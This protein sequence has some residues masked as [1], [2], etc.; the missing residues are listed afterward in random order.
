MDAFSVIVLILSAV[1]LV[2]LIWLLVTVSRLKSQPA[3]TDLESSLQLLKAELVAKQAESLVALRSSIDNANRLLNERL[4]EGTTALDRRMAVFSEIDTKL[5]QLSTQAQNIE[6]IGSNIS[7]LSELLRAPKLRG[8]LGEFF[9]ENLLAEILPASMYDSQYRFATG[10]CVDA[11]IKL[12][13][14]LVP[15]DAKFPLEAY[16]RLAASKADDKSVRKEFAQALKRHI[17]AISSKYIK[18]DENTTEFAIMYV[19]AE[20]VYYQLVSQTDDGTLDYALSKKVIPSSPGHLYGFLASIAAIFAETRLAQAGVVD[21]SRQLL[22]GLSDLAEMLSR[23]ERYHERINGSIR[24]LS[25]SFEKARA[26]TSHLADRLEKL[27]HPEFDA[28]EV[29]DSESSN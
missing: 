25:A 5:G 8:N 6:S 22:A 27:R 21:G 28:D 7:S 13:G 12:G 4:A 10:Q 23:L 11:V 14:K 2:V 26:E 9:L 24:S 15:V 29:D 1:I 17:D 3:H 16:E 18:P 20:A 19:P